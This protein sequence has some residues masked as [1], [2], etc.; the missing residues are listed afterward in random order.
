[1][2]TNRL[3]K[4]LGGRNPTMNPYNDRRPTRG[5]ILPLAILAAIILSAV[6]FSVSADL[7]QIQV[8]RIIPVATEAS[9]TILGASTGQRLSGN[10]TA[11]NFD[12]TAGNL[13]A[14]AIAA[15][16]VNGDG[17]REST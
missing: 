3:H 12:V 15:G 16:D 5:R 14:R 11:G 4:N 2:N 6:I 17:D 8:L 7:Q 1:T 10:G 9:A 13:R